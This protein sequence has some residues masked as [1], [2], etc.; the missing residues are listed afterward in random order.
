MD[1]T[2][3]SSCSLR[4]HAHFEASH[5]NQVLLALE[6]VPL[7][8]PS[9]R[10]SEDLCLQWRGLQDRLQPSCRQRVAYVAKRGLETRYPA[11]AKKSVSR[12]CRSLRAKPLEEKHRPWSRKPRKP[13]KKAM[14]R[15]MAA[16]RGSSPKPVEAVNRRDRLVHRSFARL[17][18][19]MEAPRSWSRS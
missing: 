15:S 12:Y 1:H 18:L 14:R 19:A 9:F 2:G 6:E 16:W 5:F 8:V 7:A 3:G 10:A 13:S 17:V 11:G 4:R